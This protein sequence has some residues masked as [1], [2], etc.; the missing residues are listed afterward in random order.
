MLIS[1]IVPVYNVEPYV[2]H[3]I[4]S[5]REQTYKKIEILLIDDGSTDQSGRLCDEAASLDTR[6]KVFHTINKGLSQAR[7]TGLKKALGDYIFF[8]DSDD[9]IEPETLETLLCL[10][11]DKHA[12]IACCGIVIDYEDGRKS[13]PFTTGLMQLFEKRSALEAMITEKNICSVA[14]NKLYKREVIEGFY[15][16]EN[17]YHEDEFLTYKILDSASLTAF[18]PDLFYHCLEREGSITKQLQR[19]G[20]L[21]RLE[22]LME[23]M[24][25]FE[26]KNEKKLVVLTQIE[27]LNYLK[28]LYRTVT[29]DKKEMRAYK[30]KLK[31]MYLALLRKIYSEHAMSFRQKLH[32][33]LSFIKLLVLHG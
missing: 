31:R 15:Y 19:S 28:Y 22:A 6:I 21:L 1:V 26:Q 4:N 5:I 24:E 13:Q 27:Y 20:S 9:Y 14:W 11:L 25:Y 8:V 30:N 7:N 32:A 3:C 29:F 17:K 23:R 18:I 2:L 12:D 10:A 33:A 16:P